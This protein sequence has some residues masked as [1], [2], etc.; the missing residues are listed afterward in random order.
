MP[1]SRDR[2][3]DQPRSRRPRWHLGA[4]GPATNGSC[5]A[6]GAD[7]GVL[8]VIGL[9]E[10]DLPG[11]ECVDA[12]FAAANRL[13]EDSEFTRVDDQHRRARVGVPAR[14]SA[15]PERPVRG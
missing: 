10:E 1:I 14:E 12:A 15:E 13:A 2:H 5:N 8:L 9:F 6:R 4:P 7:D 11:G 3:G